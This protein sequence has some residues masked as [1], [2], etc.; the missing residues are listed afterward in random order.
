MSKRIDDQLRGRSGRQGNAGRSM[1]FASLEDEIFQVYADDKFW[2]YA[3]KISWSESGVTD[4]KLEKYLESAQ[5]IA[6]AIAADM[7]KNSVE[8][9]SILDNYSKFINKFRERLL[10][11]ES[12]AADVIEHV[13]D[14]F[15]ELGREMDNQSLF[16]ARAE[17]IQTL[18]DD[19]AFNY[20]F[21]EPAF[22]LMKEIIAALFNAENTTEGWR[23]GIGPHN[24]LKTDA[25]SKLREQ[26]IALMDNLWEDY[27]ENTDDLYD[28]ISI[29][30]VT[31]DP[32][33]QFTAL[34]SENF[35]NMRRQL[36]RLALQ[37]LFAE[38]NT[39]SNH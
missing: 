6:E 14:T 33:G 38:L 2:D 37:I 25:K 12:V 29:E 11:S 23:V 27:L 10:T 19:W 34:S 20:G 8:L 18:K 36:A 31:G 35:H 32:I 24:I 30:A 22:N 7:R 5:D 9:D 13:R 26:I 39:G 15:N 28:R 3:E 21:S 1:L 4:K 16:W 17:V